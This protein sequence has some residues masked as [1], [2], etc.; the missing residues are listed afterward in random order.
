MRRQYRFFLSAPKND[1]GSGGGSFRGR[2]SCASSP[3]LTVWEH[4][5]HRNPSPSRTAGPW[6]LRHGFTSRGNGGGVQ[7]STSTFTVLDDA[8]VCDCLCGSAG[9]ANIFQ[10]VGSGVG[11]ELRRPACDQFYRRRMLWHRVHDF[12]LTAEERLA[13]QADPAFARAKYRAV[14]S[15]FGVNFAFR[16][17]Q[18][19]DFRF[20]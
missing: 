16:P 4:F 2:A 3:L 12:F 10:S 14:A 7:V 18:R 11:D 6:H 17:C 19:C 13:T 15:P 1:L 5:K 8:A 20:C 9:A